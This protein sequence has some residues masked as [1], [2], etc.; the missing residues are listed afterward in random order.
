MRSAIGMFGLVFL[1]V[2]VARERQVAPGEADKKTTNVLPV[3]ELR[4]KHFPL[5]LTPPF[6]RACP[7][8]FP[9]HL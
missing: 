5:L 1:V 6:P 7:S 8:E 4:N 2:G 3:G 9:L